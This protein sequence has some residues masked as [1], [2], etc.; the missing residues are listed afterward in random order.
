MKY[1]WI[2]F[3]IFSCGTSYASYP[4]Y[5]CAVA[6]WGK[7]TEAGQVILSESKKLFYSKTLKDL[8]DCVEETRALAK[9]NAESK[10]FSYLVLTVNMPEKNN[11][12]WEVNGNVSTKGEVTDLMYNEDPRP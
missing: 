4:I 5:S 6:T 12:I 10:F 7:N 3:F 1:F 8:K 2:L 11:T 9:E